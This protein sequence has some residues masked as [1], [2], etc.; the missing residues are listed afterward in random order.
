[1]KQIV[2]LRVSM[3]G[4]KSFFCIMAG[5]EARTKAMKIAVSVPGVEAASLKGNDKDQIE[6]KGEGIDTVK[7]TKLI[8]KKVG[9]AD[10]VSVAEEKKEDKKEE[11]K[12]DKKDGAAVQVVWPYA[13]GVPN[14]HPIYHEM[15]Q[16]YPYNPS[17]SIM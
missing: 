1:M 8:R 2:V 17:C 3:D 16:E 12:E 15:N 10:I 4:Q 9:H 11:K 6:V 5:Q 13:S 14:Y 7:L